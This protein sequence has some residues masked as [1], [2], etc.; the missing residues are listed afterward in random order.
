MTMPEDDWFVRSFH[1]WARRVARA[2]VARPY[3]EVRMSF[4]VA[5][6]TAGIAA[7][8]DPQTAAQTA[9]AGQTTAIQAAIDAA[10]DAIDPLAHQVLLD[11][12]I[13]AQPTLAAAVV[14]WTPA[15][16]TP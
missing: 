13:A 14:A 7:A 3:Q 15:V 16:P 9:L 10:G 12:L 1:R 2:A 11:D 4:D 5:A 8:P 6:V